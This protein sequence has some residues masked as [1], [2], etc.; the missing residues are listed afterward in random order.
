MTEIL[1]TPYHLFA[2]WRIHLANDD[3]ARMRD[4]T[5]AVL[6]HWRVP[7]TCDLAKQRAGF[8]PDSRPS[9]EKRRIN[10]RFTGNTHSPR[11]RDP[12]GHCASGSHPDQ[13]RGCI[14][15]DGGNRTNA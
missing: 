4:G 7:R 6:R 13:D 3:L 2:R 14:R 15:P 5:I 1:D 10:A 9:V 11:F 8:L 12:D